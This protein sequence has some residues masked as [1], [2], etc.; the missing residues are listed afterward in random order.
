MEYCA[1]EVVKKGQSTEVLLTQTRRGDDEPQGGN[2]EQCLTN[3]AMHSGLSAKGSGKQVKRFKQNKI[4]FLFF[5]R[6]L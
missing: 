4:R 1:L 6:L 5:K 3:L 2:K